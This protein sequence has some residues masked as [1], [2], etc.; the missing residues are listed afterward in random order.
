[1]AERA[2]KGKNMS[3]YTE[4][5]KRNAI[6]LMKSIGITKASKELKISHCTIYRWCRELEGNAVLEAEEPVNNDLDSM[7]DEQAYQ[8]ES[9][10]ET[11]NVD[12]CDVSEAAAEAEEDPV[13]DDNIATAMA[14][15][16]IENAHLREVIRHLRD[17]ISGL[18]DHHLL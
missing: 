13:E 15:L 1:M 17:T 11:N 7:M 5:F 4:E 6:E 2:M 16:V 3:K 10:D 9:A 12:E 8:D 18:T 14:L